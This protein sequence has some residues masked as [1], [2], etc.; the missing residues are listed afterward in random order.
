MSEP[1]STN[2]NGR[3]S[4]ADVGYKNPPKH[5]QFAKGRSGNP[6]GRP[7][8]PE[9]ISIK[10]LLDGQQ[11]GKNGEVISKREALVIQML[12]DAA[13]GNQRAFSKFISFMKKADMF[14]KEQPQGGGRGIFFDRPRPSPEKVRAWRIKNGLDPDKEY[15]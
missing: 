4:Q 1:N 8:R 2:E 5:T 3:P 9:G 10:E 14:R 12:N 13:A 15:T 11:Q 7:K 6:N